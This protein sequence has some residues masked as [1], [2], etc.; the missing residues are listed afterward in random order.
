[1]S[2]RITWRGFILPVLLILAWEIAA[3]LS[4]MQ[5]DILAK[6]SE[7]LPAAIA[8]F[9]DGSALQA[10]LE[11]LTMAGAGLAIGGVIGLTF[12]VLLGLFRPFNRLMEFSIES[13]RPI[14]S[15]ALLPIWML[16]YGL[17]Y[18]MEIAIVAWATTWPFLILTRAAVAGVHP[19][20]I[21]V[22]RA[23]GFNLFQRAYK[24]VL[25]AALPRIFVALRLAVGIT[26]IVAVT[27]EIT[28]NPFGLG[29]AIMT[30]EMSLHPATMFALIFWVGIIGWA[31][32]YGLLVL[33]R[34]IFS[35]ASHLA[36]I[37]DAG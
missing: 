25:P 32:S 4:H 24:I 37:K 20:M 5:S 29:Y 21:E 35:Y 12:G 34:R 26:L 33:Q 18:R 15:I 16:I 14:P 17:G 9:S 8:A 28:A 27:M 22:S 2:G 31:L 19:R 1:V 11:T 3:R 30:A 13:L 36:E 6:P 23:M 10:T 7:I